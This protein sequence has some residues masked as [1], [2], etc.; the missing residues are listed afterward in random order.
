MNEAGLSTVPPRMPWRWSSP[1]WEFRPA[2]DSPWEC[3]RR[4]ATATAF[5][6]ADTRTK[7]QTHF[8]FRVVLAWVQR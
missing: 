2:H 4:A 5:A 1:D 3:A 8:S 7:A 6:F